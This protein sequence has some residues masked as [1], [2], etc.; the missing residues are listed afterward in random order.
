V[1]VLGADQGLALLERLPDVEGLLLLHPAPSSGSA[2][3]EGST[4]KFEERET[5]GLA[6]YRLPSKR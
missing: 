6:P 2:P 1:M 3:T 4:P 5:S